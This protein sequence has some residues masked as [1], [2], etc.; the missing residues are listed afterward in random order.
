MT[1]LRSD[2]QA[3][4]DA[5]DY[6]QAAVLLKKLLREDPSTRQANYVAATMARLQPYLSLTDCRIAFLRS[7]TVEPLTPLLKA[8]CFA[9]GLNPLV[10]VED[11]NVYVQKI[12]DPASSLYAFQPDIVFLAVRTADVAPLLWTGTANL[13]PSDL[14]AAVESVLAE[15]KNWVE[16]FRQHTSASLIVYNLEQ[17]PFTDKGVLDNQ[18]SGSQREAIRQIN[19]GLSELAQGYTG[20][21]VL[22]YDGLIARHGRLN[23]HDERKWLTMRMPVTADYLMPLVDEMMRFIHPLTGKVSKALAVDLDNT[24]WGGVIGEDGIDGIQIGLEYPGAAYRTLQQVILNLYH[25]GIIL[26]ICSKNNPA[27][28]LDALQNHPEML[29][30]PEHFAVMQINW[31]DKAENLRRIAEELNIGI[32][33]LAFLDDNPIE[34]EWVRG[35]LPEVYVIDLPSEP[36]DYAQALQAVPVFER[37]RLSEEDRQRSRYYAAERQRSELQTQSGSLED[38]YYSLDMHLEIEPLSPRIIPRVAQ[39]T[40]K[41]NQFNMT[42]RRYSEQEIA[43]MM[44]DPDTRVLAARVTDRFGDNGII[45]VLILRH[46]GDRTEIDTFLMSCRVIGRTIETALLAYAADLARLDGASELHGWFIPTK[47]NAPALGI[48][49]GHSFQQIQQDGEKTLWAFDLRANK[50]AFPAWIT[51]HEKQE[52]P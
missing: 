10:Q 9:A 28:A 14:A 44:A 7:F 25:R 1:D 47:K 49:E 4:T 17:P 43:Q 50:I 34:R 30:R 20:V 37:L 22:D 35:Q 21:Y 6:V 36:L 39:L 33:A 3:A 38:F 12:I 27:D 24:L 29:L 48:Y 52:V 46:L 23:W 40:Q 41:T 8:R 16:I 31:Q 26:A 18:Q 19:H 32:D 2:I 45:G 13:S 42:N 15:Y 51:L 5:G 11:F